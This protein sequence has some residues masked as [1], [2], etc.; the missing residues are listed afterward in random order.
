MELI[1]TPEQMEIWPSRYRA[2]GSPMG[3]GIRKKRMA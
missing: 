3:T 2:D 1:I